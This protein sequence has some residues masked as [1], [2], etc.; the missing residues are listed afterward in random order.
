MNKIFILWPME[1]LIWL[2]DDSWLGDIVTKDCFVGVAM[3]AVAVAVWGLTRMAR[4]RRVRR[5]MEE[6]LE[7]A[8]QA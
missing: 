8:R 5:L 4:R 2:E 1:W 7:R 3:V 6:Y